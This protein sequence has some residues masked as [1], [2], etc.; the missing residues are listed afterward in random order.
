[1]FVNQVTTKRVQPE[2]GGRSNKDRH[3]VVR[4]LP[5]VSVSINLMSTEKIRTSPQKTKKNLQTT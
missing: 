1:M 4:L 3:D 2:I 5:L